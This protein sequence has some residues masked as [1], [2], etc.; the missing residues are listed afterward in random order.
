MA[1]N[2]YPSTSDTFDGGSTRVCSAAGL[3]FY[4]TVS[5]KCY[6]S[7]VNY[8]YV[9][10]ARLYCSGTTTVAFSFSYT[11]SGAGTASGSKS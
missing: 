6:R 11:L 2:I 5:A 10:S 7:G 3:T 1:Q 9:P 8:Y 4:V